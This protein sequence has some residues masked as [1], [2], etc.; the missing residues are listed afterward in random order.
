MD[1][2]RA[3]RRFCF[4]VAT[5]TYRFAPRVVIEKVG[6]GQFR[7]RRMVQGDGNVGFIFV[8]VSLLLNGRA[9]VFH[10]GL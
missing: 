6:V 7:E 9:E 2:S 4:R 8:W 3:L 1:L 10:R 5:V